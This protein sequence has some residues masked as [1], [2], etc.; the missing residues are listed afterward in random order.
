M[1]TMMSQAETKQ[2]QVM[3]L[4]VAGKINQK[5]AGKQLCLCVRQIKRIVRRYRAE[6]LPGL[7]SKQRGQPS[8]RKLN[9]DT[10]RLAIELMG[11]HYRDFGPTLTSEKLTERHGIALSVESTRQEML[12]E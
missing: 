3:T 6:G 12:H 4:L 1:D 5:E 10:K 9:E 2:A 8:T 7:I 11:T